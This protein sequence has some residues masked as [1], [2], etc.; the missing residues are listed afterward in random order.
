[1]DVG[2][3][4]TISNSPNYVKGLIMPKKI[5]P[6]FFILMLFSIGMFYLFFISDYSLPKLKEK[7]NYLSYL[8]SSFRD[9]KNDNENL[10]SLEKKN[11][12]EKLKIY[13]NNYGFA[14]ENEL[15]VDLQIPPQKSFFINKKN[16]YF[17][18]NSNIIF[19]T[20]LL[21]IIIASFFFYYKKNENKNKKTKKLKEI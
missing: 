19:L 3:I 9:E 10:L 8:K 14:N 7:E 4:P 2:S 18:S 20:S 6:F 15:I 17:I 12:K 16:S 5:F 21:L 11:E 13:Y 1:M